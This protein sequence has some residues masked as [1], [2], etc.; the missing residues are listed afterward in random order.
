MKEEMIENQF[1]QLLNKMMTKLNLFYI[2]LKII[3]C[4]VQLI[5]LDK[6]NYSFGR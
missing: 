1:Y 3:H 4:R 5:R 6:I 2:R